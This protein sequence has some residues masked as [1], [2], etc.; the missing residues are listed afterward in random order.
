MG[1]LIIYMMVES[2]GIMGRTLREIRLGSDRT[3]Y[4]VLGTA[5]SEFGNIEFRIKIMKQKKAF[6]QYK[7]ITVSSSFKKKKRETERSVFCGTT[8]AANRDYYS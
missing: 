2:T 6:K 1:V 3:A 7:N 4:I 8:S 5:L